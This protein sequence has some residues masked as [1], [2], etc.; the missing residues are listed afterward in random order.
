MS[1]ASRKP[2]YAVF[3]VGNVLIEWNPRF[4]FEKL[5]ADRER[6]D[7][8]MANVWDGD[9]NLE[10]DRGLPFA[11]GIARLVARHPMWE[12]EIRAILQHV[13]ARGKGIEINTNPLRKGRIEP[14]P[15]AIVVN[16]FRELGGQYLTVGSDSHA[17]H[18]VGGNLDRAIAMRLQN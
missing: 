8:F 1:A 3:D 16:W 14:N 5:I 17:P 2:R 10:L 18:H 15:P 6:L 12:A 4:L 9:L 7:W 13:V 11:D